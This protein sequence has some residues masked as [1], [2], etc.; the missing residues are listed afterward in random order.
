[1][2][3]ESF[4]TMSSKVEQQLE[5]KAV[6]TWIGALDRLSKVRLEIRSN[7]SKLIELHIFT[8]KEHARTADLDQ[9]SMSH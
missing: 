1:V 7:I 6:G 2:E 4:C 5:L 8:D 9:Y 3:T